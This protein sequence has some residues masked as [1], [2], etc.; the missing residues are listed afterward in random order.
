ME[1][2]LTIKLDIA[3]CEAEALL[4]GVPVARAHAARPRCVIAVHEYT[5]AGPNRLEL[6]VFPYPAAAPESDRPPPLKLKSNGH[7]RA[8]LRVL[9]PRR[10]NPVDESSARSLAEIDWAPAAGETFEAPVLCRQDVHL[11]VNFPRWRWTESTLAEPTPALRAQAHAMIRRFQDDLA[12]AATAD[13]LSAVRFRI[14]EFAVAYQQP[15]DQLLDRLRSHL[16]QLQLEG[17]LKWVALAPDQLVMRRLAGGRLLE[18]LTTDGQPALRTEAD[19]EG[20]NHAFP[21]RLSA[22]DGK[23][24][25]F[26]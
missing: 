11:P 4:N 12:N 1:R 7:L 25:V 23:L 2:L 15:A 19:A 17:R 18:C 26:R 20:R 10:G 16:E 9:L 6:V 21:L 3:G 24:Y 14:E 22:V 13:F 5:L 8:S